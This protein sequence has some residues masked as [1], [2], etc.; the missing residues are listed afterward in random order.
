MRRRSRAAPASASAKSRRRK[1][2]TRKRR[3]APKS[4]RHRRSP[5]AGVSEQVAL[6]KRERDEALERD[7]LRGFAPYFK[8]TWQSGIGISIYPG[9]RHAHLPG[10]LRQLAFLRR[11]CIPCGRHAQRPPEWAEVLRQRGPMISFTKAP[12]RSS[13]AGGFSSRMFGGYDSQVA[14]PMPIRHRTTAHAKKVTRSG[15]SVERWSSRGRCRP[16]NAFPRQS[17]ARARSGWPSGR[18]GAVQSPPA[19]I[20]CHT[21]SITLFTSGVG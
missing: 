5:A 8:I 20:F 12:Q 14:P 11:R 16:I 7:N 9:E 10:Q 18:L 4:T 3:T 19:A 15:D 1:T 13:I 6:F 21:G 17:R 2:A